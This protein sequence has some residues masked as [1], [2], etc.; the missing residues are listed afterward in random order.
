MVSGRIERD[1]AVLR[2][3]TEKG[4][5]R[6]C[7]RRDHRT[8]VVGGVAA[9]GSPLQITYGHRDNGGVSNG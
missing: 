8:M 9:P 2:V 6:G 1:T 3:A 7:G 4:N 5:S